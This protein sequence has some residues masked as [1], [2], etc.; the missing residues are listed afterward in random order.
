MALNSSGPISLGGATTGQSINLELGNSATALASINSTPFRTLAGVA[1]GAIALSNFYGK[2][3][4]SYWVLTALNTVLARGFTASAN[5]I[6]CVAGGIGDSTLGANNI[7][8]FSVDGVL[9]KST[10]VSSLNDNWS[11]TYSPKQV[12]ISSWVNNNTFATPIFYPDSARFYYPYGVAPFNSTANSNLNSGNLWTYGNSASAQYG[13]DW[14]LRGAFTDASGNVY[15][16]A[17][18]DSQSLGKQNFQQVSAYSFTSSGS[19]RWGFRNSGQVRD[20]FQS[21]FALVRTDSV[22]VIVG[23]EQPDRVALITL[24]SSNGAYLQGYSYNRQA[25]SDQYG[26]FFRDSSNNLYIGSNNKTNYKPRIFKV[27]SSYGVSAAKE[28]GPN[29]GGNA[30]TGWYMS[31]SIYS[32]VIYMLTSTAT[33]GLM[34]IVAIT[35]STLV[36]AW[37]LSIQLSGGSLL[38]TP[39]DS[40]ENTIV[41]TSAGIYIILRIN[42]YHNYFKLPLDGNISGTDTVTPP[43]GQSGYTVTFTKVT[44]GGS[45]CT[46]ADIS[47]SATGTFSISTMST[48]AASAA[49]G[50]P[51][52][53]VTP[54]T[55]KTVL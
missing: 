19:P 37:T 41:A 10:A 39:G 18:A 7:Y 13:V 45:M 17:Y 24:N 1:S 46:S 9:T 8:F 42:G 35:P 32:D 26:C 31:A 22:V 34:Q 33:S 55:T 53:G 54:T 6:L 11:G 16:S 4:A 51:F 44:S 30:A 12:W 5:G 20:E 40:G 23:M 21:N 29:G 25:L 52:T 27:N 49:G 15:L 36:P 43:S 3:N 48:T 28:Y 38:S 14:P 50:N 47:F 2:S